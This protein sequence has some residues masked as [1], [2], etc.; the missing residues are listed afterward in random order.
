MVF[1]E[2]T[3]ASWGE[4]T[5][6]AL[7]VRVH[8]RQRAKERLS[9]WIADMVSSCRHEGQLESPWSKWS[10]PSPQRSLTFLSAVCCVCFFLCI[11]SLQRPFYY[12]ASRNV[13]P[14]LVWKLKLPAFHTQT[15]RNKSGHIITS[16]LSGPRSQKG[17]RNWRKVFNISGFYKPAESMA[18][19]R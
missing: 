8:W 15:P 5:L 12:F 19:S 10:R 2:K 14:T 13:F 9:Q 16:I 11:F 7:T 17:F 3:K 18:F 6:F 1:K 4:N